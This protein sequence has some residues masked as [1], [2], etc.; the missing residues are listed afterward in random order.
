MS[1]PKITTIF[2][3]CCAAAGP[4]RTRPTSAKVTMA[5]PAMRL[6]DL[7]MLISASSRRRRAMLRT[8]TASFVGVRSYCLSDSPG[9]CRSPDRVAAPLEARRDDLRSG[10]G[11]TEHRSLEVLGRRRVAEPHG[12]EGFH[13][14]VTL[15]GALHGAAH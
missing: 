3:F 14:I 8:K 10:F 6:V 15:D 9:D 13:E 1:S 2:G 11:Q 12:P 7:V 4:A 5:H